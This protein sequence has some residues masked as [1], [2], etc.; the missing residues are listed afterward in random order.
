MEVRR[1]NSQAH[2]IRCSYGNEVETSLSS[3]GHTCTNLGNG[4]ERKGRT[5][6]LVKAGY[7]PPV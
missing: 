1:R 7:S 3:C 2:S 5:Q 6:K 4:S